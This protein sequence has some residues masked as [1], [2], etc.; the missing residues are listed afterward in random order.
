LHR[1]DLDRD[2]LR[3]FVEA[4]S[5]ASGKPELERQARHLGRTAAAPKRRS[6]SRLRL[7][8]QS[9]KTSEAS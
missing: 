2:E 3:A 1:R 7:T 6:S 9:F 8:W 5:Q 4:C